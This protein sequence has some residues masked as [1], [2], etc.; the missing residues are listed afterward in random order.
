MTRFDK[1]PSRWPCEGQNGHTKMYLR[2]VLRQFFGMSKI[3]PPLKKL[4]PEPEKLHRRSYDG[5]RCSH[6]WPDGFPIR[7]EFE[8]FLY[9]VSIW[10]Q[11]RD[12]VTPALPVSQRVEMNYIVYI[13]RQYTY[14]VSIV[15]SQDPQNNCQIF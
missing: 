6:E 11:F 7:A 15:L 12:S 4:L 2:K 1:M 9:R 13:F 8:H 10:C 14:I 3:L 5:L